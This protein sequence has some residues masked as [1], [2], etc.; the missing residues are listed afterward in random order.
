MKRK[1]LITLLSLVCATVCVFALAACGGGGH[2]HEWAQTWESNETHHWH[3]CIADGCFITDVSDKYGYA[4]HDFSDGDCVCGYKPT[5]NY[6]VGLEYKFD[7]GIDGYFIKGLGTAT[8]N[9]IV[10]PSEYEGKPVTKIEDRAFEN[11]NSLTSIKIPDGV[12][13][14]GRNAFAGC[15]SLTS[16]TIPNGV[17]DI[18]EE[19]F[20][21]CGNI[22]SIVIP[23][24]VT[25]IWP[26][27]FEGCSSLTGITIPDSVTHIGWN[28]FE[29]CSK[30][31]DINLP[32]GIPYIS[33]ATF[34][35]CISLASITIPNSVTTISNNAF[36]GCSKLTNVTIPEAV[37]QLGNNVFRDCSSLTS[38]VIPSG[39]SKI[40]FSSFSGC[41]SLTN[42]IIKGNRIQIDGD[43]VFDGCPIETA[44][45]PSNVCSFINNP[46]LKTVVIT[47]GERIYD[48]ALKNCSNLE[49]ITLPATIA[50]IGDEAFMNCK[51]LTSVTFDGTKEQWR[52]ISVGSNW[53]YQTG[54]IIV[55]CT[56]GEIDYN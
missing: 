26:T 43:T 1:L 49:S 15:S 21:G 19:T 13:E 50:Y 48:S 3:N 27:A 24:G 17:T 44:T 35:G 4:E 53:S 5:Y 37:T 41:G 56:N 22:A 32:D 31:A 7:F 14:I 30:L 25:T 9:D 6:T 55:R 28:A 34:M 33:E 8:D 40:Y 20:K 42:L 23:N 29:N 46:A 54:G 2:T 36:K 18:E 47:N 16:I 12:T 51:K 10:I 38:I 52:Q 45:V 39:V 11:C